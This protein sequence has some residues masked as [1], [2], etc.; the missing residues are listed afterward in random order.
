M[1]ND[2]GPAFARGGCQWTEDHGDGAFSQ[3]G[4]S[5][6]DYFAAQALTV[7]AAMS[8]QLKDYID[9]PPEFVPAKLA[10]GAYQI[11]DAMLSERNQPLPRQRT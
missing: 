5:L 7:I 9:T 4:M 2:G 6:R 8:L 11:A 10:I 1:T 3:D